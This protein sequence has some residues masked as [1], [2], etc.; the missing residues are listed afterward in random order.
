MPE[1]KSDFFELLVS[2]QF[3]P[4][5][6]T[7]Q[8]S[9]AFTT[10]QTGKLFLLGSSTTPGE[11]SLFE[12]TFNR[13]MGL[14][15]DGQTIWMSSLYQLWRFE[16]ALE[17]NQTHGGYDRVY[18]PQV[19]YTT[20]DIDVHDITVRGDGDVVFANTRFSCLASPSETSSFT[21]R[22]TPSF[23]DRLAA[24]DRCHLNGVANVDGCPK[25]VTVVS[26]SNVADGWRD[27]RRSG[28]CIIDVQS[29]AVICEG[30]SMPHSPRMHRGDLWVLNSG[31][32][33]F[34]RVDLKRGV[35]E[36]ITLCPG[37]ARG[38]CLHDDY[39]IVGLSHCR[40]DRTFSGLEL[41]S[42]LERHGAEPRCGLLV[43][44]LRSGDAVH[45]LRLEGVVQELYDV[46]VL[47][48]VKKPMAVGFLTDEVQRMVQLGKMRPL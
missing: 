26:Q 6:E 7:Q 14:W 29:N 47:P 22:W 34:G 42:N 16:N 37:Y 5:L 30:L 8:L 28:G 45:W 4:W 44:D 39:A 11:L 3:Q 32:G 9:L 36:P 2:R 33:Y 18:V 15:S 12:R 24:E 13:C 10:Y 21:P 25:Y 40:R 48:K 17:A 43:V 31:T 23:I 38:L 1:D 27:H 20:G 46:V 19:G 41:E 35:F